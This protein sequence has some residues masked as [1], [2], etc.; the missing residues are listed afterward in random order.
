MEYTHNDT[1][2]YALGVG[3]GTNK[4][5]CELKYIYENHEDFMVRIRLLLASLKL[6]SL[7]DSVVC[8]CAS[9]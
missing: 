8:D 3:A 4:E 7:D 2:L 6:M 5:P 1:I 9:V